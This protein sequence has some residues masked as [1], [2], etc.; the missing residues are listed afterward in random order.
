MGW[1][2]K[3]TSDKEILE[4]DIHEIVN[5]N[6]YAYKGHF[7][8]SRQ[9]WGWST[10]VDVQNPCK[11]TLTV[12]GAYF[13]IELAEPATEIIKKMLEDKGYKIKKDKIKY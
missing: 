2:I 7:L 1:S 8:S 10:A 9:T 4:S 12:S 11:N 13:S 5:S 3:L 6:E